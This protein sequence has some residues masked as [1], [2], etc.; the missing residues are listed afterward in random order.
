MLIVVKTFHG[1]LVSSYTFG[2]HTM[3]RN[4]TNVLCVRKDLVR[5]SP[6][7]VTS[8]VY[9]M[10]RSN[11][12]GLCVTKGLVREVPLPITSG[13]YTTERSCTRTLIAVKLLAVS[14]V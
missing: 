13:V 14:R 11:T 1:R 8:G 2:L 10:E 9:T 3:V 12:G 4:L 6:L 5:A 7:P